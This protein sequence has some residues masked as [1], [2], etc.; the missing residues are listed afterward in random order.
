MGARPTRLCFTC[1]KAIQ[2]EDRW[3]IVNVTRGG[4]SEMPDNEYNSIFHESCYLRKGK[5]PVTQP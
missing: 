4:C 1:G 2:P 5:P 3:V